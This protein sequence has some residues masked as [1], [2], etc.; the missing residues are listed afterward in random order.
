MPEKLE[1]RFEAKNASVVPSTANSEDRTVDV[2]WY[3]G[4]SVPRMNYRTGDPYEL[5][6]DMAGC[7]MDRLNAGA[8]VFDNHMTG[9]DFVSAMAETLGTRAQVGVVI[10]AWADGLSG[11][12]TLKF[13]ASNPDDPQDPA[14]RIWGKI[15]TGII[16]NLSFGTWIYAMEQDGDGRTPLDDEEDDDKPDKFV[17]TDWEP[18]EISPVC[19]PADFQTQFLSAAKPGKPAPQPETTR[20][21]AQIEEQPVMPETNT[22]DAG[23][24]ARPNEAALAAAREAGQKAERERRQAIQLAAA[25]FSQQLGGEFV[26]N[27]IDQG[28][29]VEESRDKLLEKLAAKA[30]VDANGKT[31]DPVGHVVITREQHETRREQMTAA[32]LLRHDPKQYKSLED[33]GREYAGFSLLEMARECL[34]SIGVKTRGMSKHEIA[35]VALQGHFG[36]AEFFGGMNSTSDFPSILANVANKTLRQAYEQFPSNWK[37]FCRMVTASDFKPINRVQLSDLAALQAINEHGEFHRTSPSDSKESYSLATYGE[38]VAITR[39]VI[40]NDDLQAFTRIPAMLGTA[41]AR[42]E[43]DTVWGVFTANAAMFDTVALFHGSHSNLN[44]GGGSALGTAGLASARSAMRLQTGPKG[45]L[46]N[47]VPT[48][49]IIPAALEQTADTLVAPI[50]IASSDFTKVVPQWIRSLQPI[51]EPR[52]DAN[53]SAAWYLA[54]DNSMIDTLEYCYLEGQEGVF[55]E[56][57]QGFDVDGV[58]IKARMDFAAA[59]VEY[60]GLQKNVGS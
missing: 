17:A 13:D 5:R 42:L 40:I 9:A 38:I 18:F 1:M 37:A 4:V 59:A 2:T 51:V 20:A 21:D 58:E 46:L 34:E 12:A 32:L 55:T 27:L 19:V 31:F 47:L 41:A 30:K 45:T 48:F 16:Q 35:R 11:K 28:L 49:L 44:S 60:R 14:N 26:T 6:L 7:R 15:S 29:S 56:T 8:P 3:T 50:N 24:G 43:A 22:Q 57:R 10:K 33:K 36:A 54:A 39:K 23:T 25:P 53:S 52:L